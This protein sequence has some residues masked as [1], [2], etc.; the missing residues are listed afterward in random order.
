M[1]WSSAGQLGGREEFCFP[2]FS[3]HPWLLASSESVNPK[4]LQVGHQIFCIQKAN[5]GRGGRESSGGSFYGPDT[6][7]A[8]NT[9]T[10]IVLVRNQPPPLLHPDTPAGEA[11]QHHFSVCHPGGK[12]NGVWWKLSI[13]LQMTLFVNMGLGQSSHSSTHFPAEAPWCLWLLRRCQ[14]EMKT[15]LIPFSHPHLWSTTPLTEPNQKPANNGLW[16]RYS[17]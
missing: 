5:E 2:K 4:D 7:T 12:R 10:L 15:E 1:S 17:L 11:E 13:S 14:L 9:S 8:Y 16:P 3:G 6:V